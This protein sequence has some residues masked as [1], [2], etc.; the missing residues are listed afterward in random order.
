MSSKN[1]Q[2]ETE[3]VLH[4]GSIEKR[5]NFQADGPYGKPR[6][7]DSMASQGLIL[8]CKPNDVGSRSKRNQRIKIE[9]VKPKLRFNISADTVKMS[10]KSTH[11]RNE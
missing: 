11:A 10:E 6:L 8:Q 2:D 7:M 9:V 4:L 3:F 1:V 5:S